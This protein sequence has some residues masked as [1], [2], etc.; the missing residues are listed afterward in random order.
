[1]FL[2]IFCGVCAVG[3]WLGVLYITLKRPDAVR[4][5]ETIKDS[6]ANLAYTI[7]IGRNRKRPYKWFFAVD[8]VRTGRSRVTGELGLQGVTIEAVWPSAEGDDADLELGA[9]LAG[10][11]EATR[12]AAFARALQ[13]LEVLR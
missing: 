12:D 2:A 10:G 1:M 13:A 7:K 11:P 3:T 8:A 4:T 5:V 6:E 9:E